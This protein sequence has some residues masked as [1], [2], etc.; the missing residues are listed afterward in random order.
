MGKGNAHPPVGGGGGKNHP[1]F[2]NLGRPGT[3]DVQQV[4]DKSVRFCIY[5]FDTAD[6]NNKEH[7]NYGLS[8]SLFTIIG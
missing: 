3:P 2:K 4:I 5:S 6:T 7:Q 8:H 1:V